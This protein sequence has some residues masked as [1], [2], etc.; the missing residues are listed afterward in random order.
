MGDDDQPIERHIRE[1]RRRTRTM[2]TFQGLASCRRLVYVAIHKL[3]DPQ[4]ER[5]AAQRDPV[6][7]VVV[8]ALDRPR[9]PQEG[10]HAVRP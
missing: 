6:Q 3:G 9:T 2:G 1:L 7:P 5:P 4:A 8:A 10:P